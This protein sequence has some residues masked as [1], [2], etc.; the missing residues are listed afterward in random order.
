MPPRSSAVE[1]LTRAHET[2]DAACFSVT[3]AEAQY[4][5]ARAEY[6]SRFSPLRRGLKQFGRRTQ[7][8]RAQ[9]VEPKEQR[10]QQAHMLFQKAEELK[11]RVEASIAQDEE[12]IT[13][14]SI[15]P[16]YAS[17]ISRSYGFGNRSVL[18]SSIISHTDRSCFGSEVDATTSPSTSPRSRPSRVDT[19]SSK[20]VGE[21][22]KSGS[23]GSR[24]SRVGS[25]KSWGD[26][27][28]RKSS[29]SQGLSPHSEHSSGSGMNGKAS[30]GL[31][32]SSAGASSPP[33][34]Q[35]LGHNTS[36][37]ASVEERTDRLGHISSR[38]GTG[39]VSPVR[40]AVK[41]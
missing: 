6:E 39:T 10:L 22:R 16:L 2:S 4:A 35:R 40:V 11:S 8:W 41:F 15:D 18:E 27:Q 9:N 29:E 14:A 34:A 21:R 13:D 31:R 30:E 28:R 3:A 19:G 23:P 12:L 37:R 25:S 1:F 32:R 36:P 5:A 38:R 33:R 7:C 26:V 20:S 24:P 17:H